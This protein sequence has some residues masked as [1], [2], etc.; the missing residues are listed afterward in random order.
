MNNKLIVNITAGVSVALMIDGVI[1]PKNN[2]ARGFV[3]YLMMLAL[4]SKATHNAIEEYRNSQV[5]NTLQA[6][7]DT[8]FTEEEL[9]TFERLEKEMCSPKSQAI[10]K[11]LEEEMNNHKFNSI[12]LTLSK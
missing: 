11:K 7:P 1:N 10:F 8:T 2:K 12:D 9:A 5:V 6:E 4:V 3:S